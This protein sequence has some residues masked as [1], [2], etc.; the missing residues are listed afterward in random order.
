MIFLIAPTAHAQI[1][2]TAQAG[3]TFLNVGVGA[4]AAGMGGS[5]ITQDKDISSIF[6]NPAGIGSIDRGAFCLER[7]MW[8]AD[9][10]QNSAAIAYSFGKYG[11]LGVNMVTMDYGTF[12]G[13]EISIASDLF[14]DYEETGEFTIDEYYVGLTY[15]RMISDRF[16][17]GGQVKYVYQDLYENT[18]QKGL[19]P[20]KEV[21]NIVDVFAFDFG[22]HYKTGFHSLTFAMCARN[23]SKNIQFPEQQEDFSL[24]LIFTIGVSMDVLDLV[25]SIDEQHSLLLSFDGIHPRD[26]EE[27]ASF[28]AEYGFMNLMFLRAGYKWNFSAEDLSF[29]AGFNYDLGSGLSIRV[30][31]AFTNMK[32]FD[33]VHRFSI[34]GTF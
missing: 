28:G 2:K 24:P 14:F 22:T 21:D 34:A 13:T 17:V 30:D 8:F 20:E 4:R 9:I 3:M 6:W 32:Y 10:I 16:L 1:E 25:N 12:Y 18:I 29:G 7:N 33:P 23:F 26:Y 11:V 31:Y 5:F 27:K 15:S 19:Y